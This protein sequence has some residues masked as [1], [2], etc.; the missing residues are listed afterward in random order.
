M[1]IAIKMILPFVRNQPVKPGNYRHL[2]EKNDMKLPVP[3]VTRRISLLV[4]MLLTTL[5]YG[6]SI[7]NN[8]PVIE[9]LVA[10]SME[11]NQGESTTIQC[12][13]S[14]SDEDELTYEWSVT[15][16]TIEGGDSHI[17]WTAPVKCAT[18]IIRVTVSDDRGGTATESVRIKVIKPG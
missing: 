16:G 3:P 1:L 7:L 4:L 15:G 2:T 11:I 17:I 12:I 14:D 6:C 5:I 18:A 9:S 8:P 10:E 13:A